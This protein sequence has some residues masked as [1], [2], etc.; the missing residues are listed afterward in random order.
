MIV[1]EIFEGTLD[2]EKNQ[3]TC[4]ERPY[5]KCDKLRPRT[6]G[7]IKTEAGASNV[8]N[9]EEILWYLNGRKVRI[10]IEAE[11]LDLKIK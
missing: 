2:L 3:Y 7:I 6:V 1:Y 8:A 9:V 11:E 10:T 4:I 5:N